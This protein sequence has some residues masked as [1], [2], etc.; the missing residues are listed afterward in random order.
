M[1]ADPLFKRFGRSFPAGEVIFREGAPGA[2]MYVLRTGRV[3]I[4]RRFP[5]GDRTLA[6]LGPGEFFGEMAILN[7]RPRTATAIAVEPV[8]ALEIDGRTFEAMVVGNTEIAVRLIRKL[9][10]RLDSANTFIETLLERDPRLRVLK[11]FV[12][13]ADEFAVPHPDGLYCPLAPRDLASELGMAEEDV[14]VV[15]ERVVRLKVLRP[16]ATGGWTFAGNEAL[17]GFV[18]EVCRRL[19]PAQPGTVTAQE[20]A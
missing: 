18:T 8:E 4:E 13:V 19:R 14:A 20:G 6:V 17:H 10:A 15:L 16:A 3:R 1:P 7:N 9:A 11:G 12:R 5:T 2:V